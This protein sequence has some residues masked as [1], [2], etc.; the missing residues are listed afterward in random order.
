[1]SLTVRPEGVVSIDVRPL[2]GSARQM[3]VES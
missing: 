1:M 2:G 3:R